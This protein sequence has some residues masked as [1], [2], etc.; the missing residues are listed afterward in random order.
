MSDRVSKL[1]L[2]CAVIGARGIHGRLRW[3]VDDAPDPLAVLLVVDHLGPCVD[4]PD[5]DTPFVVTG[6]K[7]VLV[8]RIEEYRAAIT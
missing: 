1:N 3:V 2:T 6:G 5:T 7:M 4:I 8:V